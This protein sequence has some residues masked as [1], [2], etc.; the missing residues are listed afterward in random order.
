MSLQISPFTQHDVKAA[1]RLQGSIAYDRSCTRDVFCHGLKKKRRKAMH[2]MGGA[3]DAWTCLTKPH[4]VLLLLLDPPP[5][6]L[7]GNKET[8]RG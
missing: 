7:L 1:M 2:W 8:P 4:D 3:S 5:T 6:P